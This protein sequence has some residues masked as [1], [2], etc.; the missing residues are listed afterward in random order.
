M[1]QTLWLSKFRFAAENLKTNARQIPREFF[2]KEKV[3]RTFWMLWH[4]VYTAYVFPRFLW[5]CQVYMFQSRAAKPRVKIC[6]ENFVQLSRRGARELFEISKADWSLVARWIAHSP[7][8]SPF[9]RPIASAIAPRTTH[10]PAGLISP[11]CENDSI[12][13]YRFFFSHQALNLPASGR[14]GH[15]WKSVDLRSSVGTARATGEHENPESRAYEVLLL[16]PFAL[17]LTPRLNSLINT[18]VLYVPRPSLR[19]CSLP[20]RR[21]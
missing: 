17:S 12:A 7:I 3:T 15:S 13:I 11:S 10:V 16:V 8:L 20:L 1:I 19:V 9:V 4:G 5:S 21:R 18:C 14:L 2:S 6:V